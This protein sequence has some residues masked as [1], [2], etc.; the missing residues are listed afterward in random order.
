MKIIRTIGKYFGYTLLATGTVGAVGTAL[1]LHT[2]TLDST[3]IVRI[4][5]ATVT[6]GKNYYIR[7]VCSNNIYSRFVLPC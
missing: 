3:G 5:R 6:V 4:G 2:N 1:S 7:V